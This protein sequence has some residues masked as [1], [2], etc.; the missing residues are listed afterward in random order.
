MS[1]RVDQLTKELTDEDIRALAKARG[2]RV[3]EAFGTYNMDK[4]R[5]IPDTTGKPLSQAAILIA[6]KRGLVQHSAKW[7]EV[8]DFAFR[9]LKCAHAGGQRH[10]YAQVLDAIGGM[11]EPDA[12]ETDRGSGKLELAETIQNYIDSQIPVIEGRDSMPPGNNPEWEEL[13]P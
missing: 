9:W 2:W 8:H 13:L 3:V 7:W 12:H 11:I 10:A 4:T 1:A 5:R 6:E